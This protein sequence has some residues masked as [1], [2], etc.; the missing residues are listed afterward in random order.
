MDTL[1]PTAMR[2]GPFAALAFAGLVSSSPVL[3]VLASLAPSVLSSQIDRYWEQRCGAFLGD[4]E[5]RAQPLL[6]AL[7]RAITL[8][9]SDAQA[10]WWDTD[11]GQREQR[12]AGLHWGHQAAARRTE[13]A[14]GALRRHLIDGAAD[15]HLALFEDSDF[16]HGLGSD[17]RATAEVF[18]RYLLDNPDLDMAPVL[19]EFVAAELP[20]ALAAAFADQF[21]D[22][23]AAAAPLRFALDR[24]T[25][26]LLLAQ[27][28]VLHVSVDAQAQ[29]QETLAE[30]LRRLHHLDRAEREER[31]VA[32]LHTLLQEL[33]AT[34]EE[35]R[36]LSAAFNAA[37]AS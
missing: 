35:L 20:T 17:A 24:V 12:Q 1:R 30:E 18:R 26:R 19:A 28:T 15:H 16:H 8:S 2:L 11:T 27:L 7:H 21:F 13:D 31:I 14:F 32:P 3:G 22:P 36:S 9:V 34:R 10:R 5:L 33:R 37:Q 23:E 6:G 25:Q 29:A 4:P